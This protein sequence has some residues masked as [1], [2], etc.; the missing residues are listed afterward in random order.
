MG[1]TRL[2]DELANTAKSQ[3][4]SVVRA[5]FS[6]VRGELLAF[7]MRLG[8]AVG[9]CIE[10][11]PDQP[12]TEG[13]LVQCL[14]D[15]FVGQPG[16]ASARSRLSMIDRTQY[17]ELVVSALTCMM[18]S[19]AENFLVIIEDCHWAVDDE[20]QVLIALSAAISSMPIMLLLTERPEEEMLRPKLLSASMET[21]VTVMTLSGLRESEA[22]TLVRSIPGASD[23]AATRIC[24]QAA[25]N[26]LFIIR[27]AEAGELSGEL[28]A[29][30]LAL[31]QQQLDRMNEDARTA[32][33][34]ASVLGHQFKRIVFTEIFTQP[35]I[36]HL[37]GSGFFQITGDSVTFV[38]ALIHEA[39]Y[40]TISEHDK[41]RLHLLAAKY[42]EAQDLIAWAEHALASAD[43]SLAARA[44]AAAANMVLPQNRFDLGEKFIEAGLAAGGTP[45]ERAVLLLC[46]GTARREN[47]MLHDA[48]EIYHAALNT[49][50]DRDMQIQI[51]IRLAW[52][53][54]Y[55]NE[56]EKAEQMIS[57][58]DALAEA[59]SISDVTRCELLSAH[60]RRSYFN[61][62]YEEC[63][64][65]QRQ[66][67]ELAES[68]GLTLQRLRALGGMAEAYYCGFRL[69]S[70]A[71][72]NRACIEEADR[73][74]LAIVANR[75]R[76]MHS[77]ASNMLLPGPQS[78]QL[79]EMSVERTRLESSRRNELA[80]R[81][82][83]LEFYSH[84]AERE[85]GLNEIEAIDSMIDTMTGNSWLSEY[86]V[87]RSIF[88]FYAGDR[89]RVAEIAKVHLSPP[90]DPYLGPT[91]TALMAWA[92]GPGTE[93]DRLLKQGEVIFVET[94][95]SHTVFHFHHF[96]ARAV[97]DQPERALGYQ[98]R[99]IELAGNEPVGVCALSL[100]A[101][102][103]LIGQPDR[104][105]EQLRQDLQHANL[106]AFL[107]GT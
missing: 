27:L 63:L 99:M 55:N 7:E 86:D 70:A 88:A 21:P 47:G 82:D 40:Q 52:V 79:A 5:G 98:H 71:K 100:A 34:C 29:S 58:A 41:Q 62:R 15:Q 74:G 50:D 84:N 67:H 12:T 80:A 17:T 20:L 75:H 28:P 24:Q 87:S 42:F 25:G 107:P 68:A 1:K 73:L 59:D 66:A 69:E 103:H 45:E 30:V 97:I 91:F 56:T 85:A 93:C 13:A 90:L 9:R 96:A 37:I 31:A 95:I 26:P 38:H 64:A 33:Q 35:S 72:C 65:L 83:M 81:I 48:L 32:C 2:S 61:G 106:R 39:I 105:L 23:E 104:S 49:T 53:Y 78:R 46:R 92:E 94:R 14:I 44:C 16:D 101:M 102:K 54:D 19:S 8:T 76:H 22:R 3:N 10:S 4:M 57:Q 36:E 11:L 77:Y 6:P 60:G 89:E 18:E 51:S 43:G